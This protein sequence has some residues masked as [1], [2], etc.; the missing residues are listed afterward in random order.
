MLNNLFNLLKV[1]VSALLALLLVFTGLPL[2]DFVSAQSS[3]D[4]SLSTEEYYRLLEEYENVEED[5]EVVFLDDEINPDEFEWL[6][7][8]DDTVIDTY[9]EVSI[10]PRILP[11][12]LPALYAVVTRSAGKYLVRQTLSSGTKR[13]ITQKNGKLANKAHSVT[14]VKFTKKGFP[15]FSSKHNYTLPDKY[16]K[17]SN[18]TQFKYANKNLKASFDKKPSNYNFDKNQRADIKNGKTPRGYVWHHHQDRGKL[19]LV[20][21]K[22]H[23]KTGHTGGKAIWGTK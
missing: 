10:E 7:D 1:P 6:S 12:I 22:I 18:T 4:D 13:W 11:F 2:Q 3:E 14:K 9:P 17:S 8:A 5:Y 21:K 15:I 23:D 16:L 20:N 19:Q